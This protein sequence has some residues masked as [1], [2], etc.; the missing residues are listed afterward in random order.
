M[1]LSTLVDHQNEQQLFAARRVGLGVCLWVI[2]LVGWTLECM[3]QIAGVG[4]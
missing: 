1:S 4:H 2:S 3:H